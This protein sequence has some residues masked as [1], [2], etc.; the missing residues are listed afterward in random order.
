MK[1]RVSANMHDMGGTL[2]VQR[3]DVATTPSGAGMIRPKGQIDRGARRDVEL[4]LGWERTHYTDGVVF[5]GDTV[6]RCHGEPRSWEGR[7]VVV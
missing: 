1:G 6:N 2:I 3:P 4:E 5:T 7:V